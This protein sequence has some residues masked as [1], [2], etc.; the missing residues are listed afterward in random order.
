MPSIPATVPERRAMRFSA[1]LASNQASSPASAAAGRGPR[2]C[3]IERPDRVEPGEPLVALAAGQRMLGERQQRHRRQL[4]GRGRGDAQQQRSRRASATAAGRRC[5]RPRSPSARAA[6]RRAPASWRSGV[7]RAAVLPG[8]SSASR[9][10]S[11][12]ACASAA[13]SGSSPG[14]CRSGAGSAARQS[15]PFVRKIRRGH[16]I[17]DRSRP[18]RRRDRAARTSASAAPRR[19]RRRCG[20]AIASDEIA[21]GWLAAAVV[22]GAERVP[23]LVRQDVGQPQA[24]QDDHAV[25]HSRDAR[26]QRGNRRRRGGDSGGDGESGRRLVFQRSASRRSR[27]LRRSARSIAPR[28]ARIPGQCS[29]IS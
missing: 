8:V 18:R 2:S 29:R 24:G 11:A 21:D 25:G 17:G 9:R 7:T 12:I 13:A 14:E 6:P 27:R 15:L 5:R 3:E 28:S 22:V 23:F 1:S 16:R 26:E 19:G 4:L 10:A 20:R